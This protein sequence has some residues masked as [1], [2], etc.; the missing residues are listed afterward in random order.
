MTGT[1]PSLFSSLA[2][3]AQ[4]LTVDHGSVSKTPLPDSLDR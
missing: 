3:R 1:E 4:F 2:G